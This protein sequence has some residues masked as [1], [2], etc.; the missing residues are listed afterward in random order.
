MKKIT[1][2]LLLLLL[3]V[4]FAVFADEN[5]T[6]TTS[7]EEDNRVPIYFFRGEGCP[8]CQDAEKW[9][10]SIQEEY[11]S[12]FKVVDYETWYDEDNSK[13]MQKVASARGETAEGVPY[14]IIGEKS[15]S[16]FTESYESEM[17]AQI[18]DMYEKAPSDRYDI[19]EHVEG[20]SNSK[21]AKNK[22][23]ESSN[24]ILALIVILVIT[25]GVCFGVYK[26]RSNS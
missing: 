18:N 13:L 10:D 16:G 12:K 23:K 7:G 22:K 11:G 1:C 3:I 21:K 9:F 26:A 2:L 6:V 25:G 24:D 4:P 5:E 20:G 17:I 14:I 19:M 15:W 8:H